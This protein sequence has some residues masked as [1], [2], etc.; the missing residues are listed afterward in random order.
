MTI[1][2]STGYI[3]T[4]REF[5]AIYGVGSTAREAIADARNES[6]DPESTYTTVP[7]SAA[8]VAKVETIGGAG[9][10]WSVISNATGNVVGS[11]WPSYG[12]AT[13]VL[14]SELT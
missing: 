13:A 6:G 5:N 4:D 2:E 14:D 3:A 8:L 9:F 11:G 1:P 12:N 7:A 10:S